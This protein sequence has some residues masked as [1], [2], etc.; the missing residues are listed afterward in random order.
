[1]E[2][3]TVPRKIVTLLRWPAE[4]VAVAACMLSCADYQ[5]LNNNNPPTGVTLSVVQVQDS[6]VMLRWTRCNDADFATYK[7]YY[8]TNDEVEFQSTFVDSQTFAVD[9]TKTVRGLHHGTFYYFRVIVTNQLGKMTPRNTVGATTGI[10]MWPQQ[11]LSDSQM[12]ISWTQCSNTPV[13]YYAVLSDT[14]NV[15]DTPSFLEARVVGGDSSFTVHDLAVG[16]TKWFM[17]RAWYDTAYF[18]QSL[19]TSVPGWWFTQYAPQK[20]ADTAVSLHWAT[21]KGALQYRVFRNTAQPVDSTDTCCATLAAPDTSV[22]VG[23]LSTGTTY[24]FRVYAS[25]SAGTIGWSGPQS[26]GL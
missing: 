21:A 14:I 9:T 1:M 12:V 4:L 22:T 3:T 11:W 15:I 25:S 18:S 8:D 24:W 10:G 20:A 6:T 26:M 7:V 16:T 19:I 17:I 2:K 13:Q 5:N 23:N